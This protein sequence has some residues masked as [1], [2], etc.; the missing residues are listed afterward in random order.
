MFISNNISTE[1]L[2]SYERIGV[3]FS[4]GLDSHVLLSSLS[5]SIQDTSKLV[6][7]HINHG[8]SKECDLWEKNT[9]FRN[10]V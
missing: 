7:I 9:L 3:G 1:N 5:I 2:E 10:N 8:I 4:G 6:A